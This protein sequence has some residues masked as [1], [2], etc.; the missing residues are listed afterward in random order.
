MWLSVAWLP[1]ITILG[2]PAAVWMYSRLPFVVSLY[3]Y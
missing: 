2:L 1:S 3:R